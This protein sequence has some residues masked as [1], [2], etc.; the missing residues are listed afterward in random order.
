MMRHVLVSLLVFGLFLAPSCA[1]AAPKQATVILAGNY[2]D[3]VSDG[4]LGAAEE[5]V[6]RG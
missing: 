1:A 4:P 2:W 3:G 6:C 5:W